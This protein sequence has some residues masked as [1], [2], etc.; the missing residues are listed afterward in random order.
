MPDNAGPKNKKARISAGFKALS[1]RVMPPYA[2]RGII[3]TLLLID[4]IFR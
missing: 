3:P 2:R 1:C 4:D